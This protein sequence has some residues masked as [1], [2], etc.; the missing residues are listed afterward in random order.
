[1]GKSKF[2]VRVVCVQTHHKFALLVEA[3]IYGFLD[4]GEHLLDTS[5]D[6]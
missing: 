3:I 5:F 2:V 1:M 4:T 6:L